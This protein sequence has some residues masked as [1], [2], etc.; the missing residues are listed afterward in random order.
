LNWTLNEWNDIYRFAAVRNWL[1]FT[2]QK[3]GV[4]YYFDDDCLAQPPS[5]RPISSNFSERAVYWLVLVALVSQ[6][7]CKKN[8]IKSSL[9]IAFSMLG[10]LLF[11]GR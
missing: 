9:T 2:P 4:C 6:V 8:L 1:C 3:C 10:V 7:I 5:I 11:F